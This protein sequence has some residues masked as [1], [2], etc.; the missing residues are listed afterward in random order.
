MER[1]PVCRARL[2]ERQECRRCGTELSLAIAMEKKAE[3]FFKQA[4]VCLQNSDILAAKVAAQSA[5]LIHKKPLYLQFSDFVE[6][7]T[8]DLDKF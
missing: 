7:L 2:K 1:C 4:V 3:I 8:D 5:V 6:A